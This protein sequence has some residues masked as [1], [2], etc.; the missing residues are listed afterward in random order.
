MSK[1]NKKH[2]SKFLTLTL[3]LSFLFLI[4]ANFSYGAESGVSVN[5]DVNPKNIVAGSQATATANVTINLAM[6]SSFCGDNNVSSFIFYVMK[7][8]S[9]PA[10]DT[11]VF[12][13]TITF[14]RTSSAVAVNLN[15]PVAIGDIIP[16]SN[17]E[18][19]KLYAL[20]ECPNGS[21]AAQSENVEVFVAGGQTIYSCVGPNS[22]GQNVYI[23]SPGDYSNCSDT[24]KCAGKFCQ[25]IPASL[26][27]KLVG[28]PGSGNPAPGPGNPKPGQDIDVSFNIP[29]PIQ[30]ESLIDLA[31]AIGRFLFQIAIPI[32]VI[33]IIYA[34][35]L[36]LTSG[37]NK[38][39]VATAHKALWYAVIGLAI[40]LIGQ[41]FFTLIK[42]ILNLGAPSP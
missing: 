6:F 17:G 2:L 21:N 20:I 31:K 40:I 25:E 8:N 32:A 28:G 19:K 36:Y 15:K 34:G 29:N 38:E 14:S 13:E 9:F 42:S 41:G 18:T 22:N 7:D 11:K 23:C 5:F 12:K 39:K 37:G 30:A 33:I 24:P 16:S 10:F 27:G 35:L 1:K 26:C 3:L 4:F